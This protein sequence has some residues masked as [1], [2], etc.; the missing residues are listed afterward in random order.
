DEG[1]KSVAFTL[2]YRAK[3]KTLTDDEVTPVHEKV[4]KALESELN[5]VLRKM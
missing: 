1:K 4:L 2:V 5:A 3:D